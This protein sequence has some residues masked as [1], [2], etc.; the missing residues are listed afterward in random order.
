MGSKASDVS[1]SSSGPDGTSNVT[2]AAIET[3]SL[4]LLGREGTA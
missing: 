1:V 3:T 4:K 2:A